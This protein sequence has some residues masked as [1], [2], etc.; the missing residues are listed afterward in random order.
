MHN[1]QP[2]VTLDDIMNIRYEK[3]ML[4]ILKEDQRKVILFLRRSGSE[5]LKWD[6]IPGNSEMKKLGLQAS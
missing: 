5:I 6:V 2:A 3:W 1:I 4:L